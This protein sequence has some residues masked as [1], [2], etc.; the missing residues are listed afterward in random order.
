MAQPIDPQTGWPQGWTAPLDGA[1]YPAKSNPGSAGCRTCSRKGFAWAH[2]KGTA[3]YHLY[4]ASGMPHC[5]WF[6]CIHHATGS[7]CPQARETRGD[8]FAEF[9]PKK[10]RQFQGRATRQGTVGRTGAPIMAPTAPQAITPITYAPPQ[11]A[12]IAQAQ[13]APVP[14]RDFDADDDAPLG[15]LLEEGAESRVTPDEDAEYIPQD[16]E[17]EILD[18]AIR[19]GQ[20]VLII[21]PPGCGKTQLAY[22]TAERRLKRVLVSL[23]GADGIQHEDVVGYTSLVNGCTVFVDGIATRAARQGSVLYLDEPNALPQGVRY[24]LFSLLDFRHEMTIPQNAGEIVKAAPGFCVI[25]AM[26]PEGFFGTTP[27]SPAFLQRFHCVIRLGYL[28]AD[29]EVKLLTKRV[30]GLAVSYAKLIVK[31]ATT[32]RAAHDAG[33]FPMMASV[34]TRTLLAW[35]ARVAD[36]EDFKLA[37]RAT[38]GGL[39]M[40]AS[41]FKVVTDTVDAVAPT[42]K[43]KTEEAP[44]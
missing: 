20:N 13:P 33:Q 16:G 11:P 2:P 6:G 15:S 12:P 9:P 43:K 31:V 27:L 28:P 23:Q 35:G 29:R 37:A 17:V 39:T 41:E 19:L 24:S 42:P 30:K 36:G 34:G 44:F 21:G 25:A 14:D 3:E 4:D 18:R 1:A 10:G 38:I 26:N 5:R 32:I 22:W 40:D 8:Y 7:E